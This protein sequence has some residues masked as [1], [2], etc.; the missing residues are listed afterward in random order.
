MS[1]KSPFDNRLKVLAQIGNGEEDGGA[2]LTPVS[3]AV[4]TN[5]YS[6]LMSIEALEERRKNVL[7]TIIDNKISA[8]SEHVTI[9]QIENYRNSI[10]DGSGNVKWQK[11]DASSNA[12]FTESQRNAINDASVKE[13]INKIE[14][15]FNKLI[16]N[17]KKVIK[18]ESEKPINYL[19]QSIIN[20]YA[21]L[22]LTNGLNDKDTNLIDDA[23]KAPWYEYNKLNGLEGYSKIPTTTNIIE[24]G[25]LDPQGR[26]PYL[27]QDFVFSKWWNKIP[28]NRLITLR[29]YSYPVL[30]NL[31]TVGDGVGTSNGVTENP[32]VFPPMATAIT[33]FGEDTGNN[34]KD[35][36]KFSTGY[37]WGEA[38][39]EVWD[40]TATGSTPST[41]DIM[42]EGLNSIGLSYGNQIAKVL[43]FMSVIDGTG[44][45]S[46]GAV[47]KN[48]LPPDPYKDGPYTNR[49]MGPLNRIDTVKKR[50]AGLN[51]TMDGLKIKF[52]YLARPIGGIN[53]KAIMLDILSNFMVLGS[54]SAVFFGGAHRSRIPGRRFPASSNN[55]TRKMMQ[56]DIFGEN[57]A[58]A[59]FA[60]GFNNFYK[61]GGGL[62]G[63]ATK[64]WNAAQNII[65]S[66]LDALGNP[67]DFKIEKKDDGGASKNIMKAVT[68]KMRSGMSV[69]YVQGMRALLLGEPVGDW[70]LTIG[71]PMNPIAKIGNLICTNVEVEIDE[72]AGLG[73]DDFPLGWNITVSL[74]NGMARDR[75]AIESMF[76]FGNGRIY[77]LSDEHVSSADY[78]T[79]VD[80][81]TKGRS[82]GDKPS[83]KYAK[84]KI[85]SKGSIKSNVLSTSSQDVTKTYNEKEVNSYKQNL[86]MNAIDTLT[87]DNKMQ[88]IIVAR[89]AVQKL[90]K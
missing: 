35:I 52:S 15:E 34:L 29:R 65:G 20:P 4:G 53:S 30:D 25:K 85:S 19:Q 55:V 79:R 46:G 67:F 2:T 17:Q 59:N 88:K 5:V 76:N 64:M 51:F 43:N 6:Y 32:I 12:K 86:I 69:P 7:K 80:E 50:D 47:E 41:N 62:G 37:K 26:T 14:E 28:N 1:Y 9:N 8:E 87:T 24:W 68:E 90:L 66:I 83:N 38:K 3:G 42:G 73:P 70:H 71:N 60:N 74:E 39:A 36:L 48:G 16:T 45:Q 72:E 44:G 27:F 89:H 82:T 11:V 58:I 31:N 81:A 22:H 54:S 63:L 18:S 77:E 78:V 75:D 13:N 33:Y 57:G 49:I 10:K 84:T 56:G 21:M 61:E 40:L 23:T